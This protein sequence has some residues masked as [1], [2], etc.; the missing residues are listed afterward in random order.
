ML[1]DVVENDGKILITGTKKVLTLMIKDKGF[2]KSLKKITDEL[3]NQLVIFVEANG[4]NIEDLQKDGT[5][6]KEIFQSNKSFDQFIKMYL[7]IQQGIENAQYISENPI[8]I[9]RKLNN[10][11]YD[12]KTLVRKLYPEHKPK[13]KVVNY[14]SLLITVLKRSFIAFILV[15]AVLFLSGVG[16]ILIQE[17]LIRL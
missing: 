15:F 1:I 17:L 3:N 13:H 5:D 14:N 7:S 12:L 11:L 2:K 10:E 8:Y 6:L 16:Y 4:Y 9:Q